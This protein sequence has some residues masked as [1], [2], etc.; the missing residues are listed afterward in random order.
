MTH[1]NGSVRQESDAVSQRGPLRSERSRREGDTL[2]EETLTRNSSG[3]YLS[4]RLNMMSQFVEHLA[5]DVPLPCSD[6]RSLRSFT[7]M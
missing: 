2:Q 4:K 3:V 7:S 1:T 5:V 6:R